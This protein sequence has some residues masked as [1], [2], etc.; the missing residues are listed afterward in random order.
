[1]LV[2]KIKL[3]LFQ[4][5]ALKWQ[6]KQNPAMMS[7]NNN[8][9]NNNK[10]GQSAHTNTSFSMDTSQHDGLTTNGV[11]ILNPD[12]KGSFKNSVWREVSICGHIYTMRESK[13]KTVVHKVSNFGCNCI[14]KSK[15]SS[16]GFMLLVNSVI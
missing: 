12:E 14:V 16:F 1:M 2:A 3:S 10:K 6:V 15:K 4:E 5:K 11:L 9:D 8:K 13:N 7:P